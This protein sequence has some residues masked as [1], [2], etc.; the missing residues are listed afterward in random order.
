MVPPLPPRE[1]GM[2]FH[3]PLQHPSPAQCV[4]K[5]SKRQAHRRY[6]DLKMDPSQASPH[7]HTEQ[8]HVGC[9]GG[10]T[11]IETG[12][13]PTPHPAVERGE[14]SWCAIS[15]HGRRGKARSSGVH[16]HSLLRGCCRLSAPACDTRQEIGSDSPSMASPRH[17]TAVHGAHQEQSGL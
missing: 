7:Q 15:T 8:A 3:S 2:P 4:R 9:S 6:S 13:P 1:L 5:R 10:P 17:T 11:A 12:P 14:G 16:N